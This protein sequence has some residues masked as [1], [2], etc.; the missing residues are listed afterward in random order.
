MIIVLGILIYLVAG[1]LLPYF[2]QPQ[3]SQE[4]QKHFRTEDFYSDEVSCDRAAVLE[5]NGDA[6]RERIR[7]IANA[8][9]SIYMSTF[10]FRGD[11][12][13][14]QMLAALKAAADRGVHVKVLVDG[15]SA[16]T[17]MENE[18]AFYALAAAE[19]A[20]IRI[21]NKINVFLPWRA[22]SRMHDKYI[23][24][25]ERAYI[26]GGRN[27]FDYFLGDQDGYKNYDRDVLVYNSGGEDS[28]LYQV[29]DY[30]TRI[31]NRGICSS[32][33]NHAWNFRIPSVKKAERELKQIYEEMKEKKADWFEPAD[34][35]V[36]TVEVNR[37]TLLSNPTELYAKEPQVFYALTELMSQAKEEVWIHTPYVICNDW[38]YQSFQKICSGSAAVHMMTNSATNNGNPFGSVDYVLNKKKILDTGLQMWEYEGGVSYHGKSI[39]I[40]DDMAIVGSFNMDMKSTYQDTELMLVVNSKELNAQLKGYLSGYQKETRKGVWDE[41][42]LDQLTETDAPW[43]LKIQRRVIRAVDPWIRFLF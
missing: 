16:W 37:I 12:S 5:D 9:T 19:N 24:A 35:T 32:W 22:N 42:E 21:Y 2:R 26:L 29:M 4:Y 10:D 14:K 39:T 7:L 23:I 41:G 18:A 25:D 20:E 3:V 38:M 8:K 34:Y 40:D 17:H 11:T 27:T 36:Q 15:F 6:L 33:H 28:S 30:F 13:G 1:G 31:W 43:M